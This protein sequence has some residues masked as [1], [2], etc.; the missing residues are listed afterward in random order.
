MFGIETDPN[1]RELS[2]NRCIRIALRKLMPDSCAGSFGFKDQE[3]T[4]PGQEAQKGVLI[5]AIHLD[6]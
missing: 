6:S 5:V 1:R 3:I 2:V 4:F